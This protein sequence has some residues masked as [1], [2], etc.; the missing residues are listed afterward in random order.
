MKILITGASGFLGGVLVDALS[1]DN[2]ILETLGRSDQ[3]T[4]KVDLSENVPNLSDSFSLVIH[5][6]GRA[7]TVPQ[8]EA[9]R[10]LFF[11][12]NENGTANL[13]K[14]LENDLPGAFVF[15]SSVAVYGAETGTLITEDYPLHATDPYG[16]SKIL[17]EQLVMEWCYR[18]SVVCTILRLPLLIGRGA[19]GNLDAMIRGILRGYYFNV[20]GGKA[21][22]SMLMVEDVPTVIELIWRKGGIYNVTDGHDPTYYEISKLIGKQV[23]KRI[24]S[25]PLPLA[26]LL[27][28]V[29]NFF[30]IL[31]LNSNKLA[32][33]TQSLT[34]DNSRIRQAT[35]YSPR[36]VL[37]YFSI[38]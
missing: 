3:C 31:P 26:K 14:A 37:D 19:P 20:A 22:R 11:N 38:R 27:A 4:Y 21:R 32:K 6:S 5:A 9:E 17:A 7:H 12:V 24:F 8:T 15:I 34:F 28:H 18:K 29:G 35:G 36:P 1:K 13:L 16:K 10:K 23:G 33:L 25:I 2:I 30:E